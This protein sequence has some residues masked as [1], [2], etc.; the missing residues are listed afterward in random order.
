MPISSRWPWIAAVLVLGGF[1]YV[2]HPILSPFL[3]GILIAYL[4]DPVVDR[5][6]RLKLSRTWGVIVVFSLFTLL[7]ALALLVLI[8]MLGKQLVRLYELLPQML[9]WVQN[10]ALPWVQ[11]RL[12]LN[13]G[14]WRFDQLKQSLS[15]HLGQTTDIAGLVLSQVT[16]SSLALMAWAANLLLIPVVSFYLM[17]DWDLLVGKLRGLVPRD[18]EGVVVKLVGECH[19]VLGA[20]LRGQL[21]VMLALGAMYAVGLMAIGLELGLLIGVLAGLAS[22]VPYLGVVVGIGSALLA[23]VFQFGGD[24]YPLLAIAGVFVVGQLL[25]G[26]LLTPLL[27]GDRIGLHPVA[28]IFAIMAG[29]QLFGFTGILLALPVAAVIMVLLRHVHEL[30]KR[31]DTYA[32]HA[33]VQPASR[34]KAR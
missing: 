32:G 29:G 16:A 30:Y 26:M 15:G 6:E 25:E 7:M 9:D 18:N 12:G 5:L 14:F 28:V 13:E 20:F 33:P 34:R 4:G 3:V 2:L 23:G 21:L 1:L 31:S 17:R 11:V 27:V 22:I 19:E 10:Q 24:P 8:P